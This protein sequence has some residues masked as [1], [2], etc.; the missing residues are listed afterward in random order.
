[1]A[2]LTGRMTVDILKDTPLISFD[3]SN[4]RCGVSTASK[5]AEL[6]SQETKFKAA[7]N[8]LVV[9]SNHLGGR[10][11]NLVT[12]ASTARGAVAEVAHVACLQGIAG[13]T[14]AILRQWINTTKLD[15]RPLRGE[16]SSL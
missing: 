6:L 10:V 7:L 9:E 8:S 3:I 4:T 12:E 13:L 14:T 16:V 15:G 11:G 5:L 1:M 2:T